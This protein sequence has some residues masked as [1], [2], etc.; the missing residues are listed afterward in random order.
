MCS[1]KV[2]FIF[3]AGI[4]FCK[5]LRDICNVEPKD[6]Y[7]E[8]G[9]SVQIVCQSSCVSGNIFWTLNDK[10]VSENLTHSFN[11][12]HVL[13]LR[14]FTNTKATLQCYS[15]LNHQALGGTI[16]KTFTRPKNVSCVLYYKTQSSGVP[17]SFT[18]RW[19]HQTSPSLKIKYTVFMG[20][21]SENLREICSSQ[22]TNCTTGQIFNLID[23]YFVTVRAKTSAWETDSDPYMFATE[24]IIKIAP[25]VVTVT[26]SSDRL[27]VEWTVHLSFSQL[28]CPCQVKY[29]KALLPNNETPELVSVTVQNLSIK[30]VE[31]CRNY[32]V[33]VRCAQG[34]APW[35][36]WSPEKT[37]LTKLNK[38]QIRLRMWRKVAA[39][40]ED[41]KRK[42]HLMWTGIPS[43][44]DES[45]NYT[46]KQTSYTK[47]KIVGNYTHASCGS[48][49]CDVEV[50]QHAHKLFLTMSNDEGLI[51]EKS[52]YVPAKEE[53]LP[54]ITDIQTSEREGDI[55][56][57]WMAPAQPVSGYIIDWTH[58]GKQYNWMRSAFT[59]ATLFDL[60]NRT[61]YNI[62]VTPLLEDRTGRS[63]EALQI[64]SSRGVPENVVIRDVQTSN[65][66]AL[67]NWHTESRYPCSGVVSFTV[68]YEMQNGPLLNVTVDGTK[69]D[70]FLKDLQPGTQYSV[71]V[72]AKGHDGTTTSRNSFFI[73]QKFDPRLLKV[74]TACGSILVLLVLFLLLC[75][76]IKW[77][78]FMEKPIPNPGLS[79]V[80]KWLSQ[81]HHKAWFF[82]PFTHHPENICDQVFTE[83]T[84]R[85]NTSSLAPT[86]YGNKA[87]Q[88]SDEYCD[89]SATLASDESSEPTETQRL[90]SPEE[91]IS[92]F[93]TESSSINPYRSQSSAE[94]SMPRSDKL[95]QGDSG[96]A[97][98]KT[99]PKCVYVSLNML[100][101]GNVR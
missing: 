11:S 17:D 18:C 45:L 64:C 61:E 32:T 12:T 62:T 76:A 77:R 92:S 5:G 41:G 101:Q 43:T 96:R 38:R 9:A 40:G 98:E 73:T 63:S 91:S 90:S 52:V 27:L 10:P 54:Q 26:P 66:G 21:T 13:S 48:P 31:S 8:V 80:A 15:S 89:P 4:S 82:Q 58:N 50:D 20:T 25:P 47:N 24:D 39:E 94:I 42:V 23:D 2:L 79:S 87:S 1:I 70:I 29:S 30:E 3:A 99:A 78:K 46:I 22:V 28:K 71:S 16:I 65:T 86:G 14:N 83:E 67:V 74:L 7:I 51:V 55:Q 59:N 93:S 34:V 68:L 81:N 72:E 85:A 44:C 19:D 57:S 37:I 56:V 97:Q 6:V 95:S 60:V 33:S 53:S 35:S 49:A 100:E 88:H 36:D 69:H 75:C 84:R